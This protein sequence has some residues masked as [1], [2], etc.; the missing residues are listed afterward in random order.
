MHDNVFGFRLGAPYCATLI[1]EPRP[2]AAE[3]DKPS[4][5]QPAPQEPATQWKQSESRPEHDS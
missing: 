5:T 3:H 4:R 2:K 1:G